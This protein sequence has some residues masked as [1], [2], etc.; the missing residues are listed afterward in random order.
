MKCRVRF[1]SIAACFCL[2]VFPGM[3]YAN[4]GAAKSELPTAASIY[5]NNSQL[6]RSTSFNAQSYNFKPYLLAENDDAGALPGHAEI[7]PALAFSP[8]LFSGRKVHQYLG[9][10]TVVLAGLTMVTAP[11]DGCEQGCSSQ[12]PRKT[13][14]TAHTELARATAAMAAATVATGLIFHWDDIHWED[15]FYDPDKMHARLGA[16]GA[17]L[18]LYAVDKSVNSTVPVSHAGAAELGAALM[19][20][21]IKLTW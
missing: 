17:L 9:L 20:V 4:D 12:P 3:V 6:L 5:T 13:S 1:A 2:A 21:A 7:A 14:G 11:G 18:M 19:V 8:P 15:D 16:L 10:G